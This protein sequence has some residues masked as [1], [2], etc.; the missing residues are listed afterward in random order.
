MGGKQRRRQPCMRALT[1]G[2]LLQRLAQCSRTRAPHLLL[3]LGQQLVQ[4]L[5]GAVAGAAGALGMR[6]GAEQLQQPTL[7][8]PAAR[9]R[10]DNKRQGWPLGIHTVH[11]RAPPYLVQPQQHAPASEEQ[12][13]PRRLHP[14]APAAAA[15][16][17]R[18]LHARAAQQAHAAI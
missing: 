2:A 10:T 18:G 8:Q 11:V 1:V 4:R 3:A 17:Q 13:L 14:A 15:A 9:S 12:Q 6:V 7:R 5:P 16:V